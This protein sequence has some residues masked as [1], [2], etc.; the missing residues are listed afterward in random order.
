MTDGPSDAGTGPLGS[1]ESLEPVWNVF[2][3]GGVVACPS[4]AAPMALA[5]DG[6]RSVYRFV[7][8][9]CGV[10]SPWFEAKASQVT[11]HGSTNPDLPPDSG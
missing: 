4:D 7:C 1:V 9:R 11:L 10:S 3:Q 2:R 8:S 5:V 6:A